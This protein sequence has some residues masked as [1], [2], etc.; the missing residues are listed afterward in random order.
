MLAGLLLLVTSFDSGAA[1]TPPMGWNSYDCFGYAVT[2]AQVLDNAKFMAARLKQFGWQ[3]VVIDYVWSAPKL[4]IDTPNQDAEFKPRLNMDGFGRLLPDPER[5][6][7]SKDGHGFTAL[8]AQ[9]HKMGLKFG[10]H[11]MRGIPRQAA[12]E[13]CPIEYDPRQPKP[14]YPQNCADAADKSSTCS[15]LNHMFGLNMHN[16]AGQAYLDSLFR[17][18]ADWG[19]DF[20]KVDDISEPYREAEIEGYRKAIDRCRRPIV[21]S[22]SPGETRVDHAEHVARFANMWRLLGD[23][24]DNW[25]EV[26]HAFDIAALW[27]NSRG[28]GSDGQ[29]RWPDLDMLPVGNLREYGPRTG[30]LNTHSRF[31]T[32]EART[33][34]TLWCISQSPLM[35]GGNLPEVDPD[36]LALISNKAVLDLDQ[37]GA[38][39][40]VVKTGPVTIWSAI[41][42]SGTGRCVAIFNRSEQSQTWSLPTLEVGLARA[43]PTDLWTGAPAQATDKLTGTL[44]PHACTLLLLKP[45]S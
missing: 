44:A 21:L 6:P 42:P 22:L 13:K 28:V 12:A 30:P 35:F 8:S 39:P 18:Y 2:E 24:W 11:L 29:G 34:I 7:G 31:T 16:G 20:V 26:N 14:N 41:P 3:Y 10:I 45:A 27:N 1:Q 33:V 38:S 25:R 23:F 9:L 19:V 4:G 43:T 15:W 36:T 5:F 17:Q 40:S 37:R 32:E